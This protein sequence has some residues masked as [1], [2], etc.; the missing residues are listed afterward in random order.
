LSQAN[1]LDRF[2]SEIV[3]KYGSDPQWVAENKGGVRRQLA[4]L[5]ATYRNNTN[6]NL[7]PFRPDVSQS[8]AVA[9]QCNPA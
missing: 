6:Y 3:T 5:L 8:I 9:A 4:C 2:Y 1:Q 7:E